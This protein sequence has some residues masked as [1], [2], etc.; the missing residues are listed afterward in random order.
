MWDFELG[1]KKLRKGGGKGEW[2]GKWGWGGILGWKN[3][4]VR[5]KG[6]NFVAG[7]PR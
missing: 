7:L 3:L 6:G 5:R 4:V 2:E 1:K